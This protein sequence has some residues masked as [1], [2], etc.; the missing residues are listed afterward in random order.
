MGSIERKT[1][2]FWSYI[3]FFYTKTVLMWNWPHGQETYVLAQGLVL[4]KTPMPGLMISCC[5]PEIPNNFI[6]DLVFWK[7]RPTGEWSVCRLS[8]R[9]NWDGSVFT[10]LGSRSPGHKGRHTEHLTSCH[11]IPCTCAASG[12]PGHLSFALGWHFLCLERTLVTPFTLV[13]S[14]SFT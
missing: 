14:P 6:F 5:H 8:R 2:C 13:N 11:L 7:W 3:T 12:S 9:H 1:K 10:E 4:R